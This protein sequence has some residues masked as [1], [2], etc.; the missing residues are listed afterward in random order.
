MVFRGLVYSISPIN[1]IVVLSRYFIA[2][3]IHFLSFCVIQG[4]TFYSWFV[5]F[6]YPYSHENCKFIEIS[7]FTT[8]SASFCVRVDKTHIARTQQ[9]APQPPFS[10]IGQRGNDHTD[11]VPYPSLLR[12]E[13]VFSWLRLPAH[14]RGVSTHRLLQPLRGT[15]CTGRDSLAGVPADVRPVVRN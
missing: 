2:F 12:L 14:A 3:S 7:A 5:H 15:T 11:T 13:S 9:T 6:Y 8:N 1:P 10:H 4:W